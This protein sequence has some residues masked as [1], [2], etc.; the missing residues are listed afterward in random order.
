MPFDFGRNVARPLEGLKRGLPLRALAAEGEAASQ[1]LH[2]RHGPLSGSEGLSEVQAPSEVE[3]G[4]SK[5]P[6]RRAGPILLSK[7]HRPLSGSEGL[8][9]VQ[10]PSEVEGGGSKVPAG[11]ILL[12]KCH[13]PLSGSEG[14]SEVQAPSEVEGGGSKATFR[15]GRGLISCC[16]G[17]CKASISSLGPFLPLGTRNGV[18]TRQP[19]L[20]ERPFLRR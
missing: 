15:C 16:R 6:S 18:H 14:L 8:S 11:P 20:Y 3:G 5:V 4:G 2:R 19:L 12:S 13:R 17:Q 10:A 1:C 7:C 9:E